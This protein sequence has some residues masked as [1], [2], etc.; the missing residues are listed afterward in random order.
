MANNI[1]T[2]K[3]QNT[4]ETLLVCP[5]YNAEKSLPELIQRVE[6]LYGL[7]DLLIVDDGSLDS[8]AGFLSRN[9]YRYLRLSPNQGKGAA[10]RAGYDWA[11]RN[12]YHNVLAFDSDLQHAPEDIPNFI[13]QHRKEPQAL[14]LGRR[15]FRSGSMP[16][17]RQLSNNTTSLVISIFSGAR[18]RDSQCGFR[19][20]PLQLLKYAPATSKRFM[21]ESET[22]FMLGVCGAKIRETPV[23]VIYND[24]HS[25]INPLLGIIKF[26]GLFWR[27]LWY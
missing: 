26:I 7:N 8:T 23:R 18:I 11:G 19:L 4:A 9:Q 5:S 6:A 17:M 21:Y 1:Q 10:L 22:L 12:G 2:C 16:L 20:T 27:R 13:S 3:R 14:L 15:N 25:Y 24:S